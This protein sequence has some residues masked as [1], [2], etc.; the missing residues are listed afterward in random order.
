LSHNDI[1]DIS[2]LL[3]LDYLVSLNAS[4]NRIQSADFF[5]DGSMSLQYLQVSCARL[6]LYRQLTF[7]TT[8]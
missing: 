6:P 7:Q 2:D 5:S 3:R 4:N 8:K 1:I